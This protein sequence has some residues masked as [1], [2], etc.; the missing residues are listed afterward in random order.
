MSDLVLLQYRSGGADSKLLTVSLCSGRDAPDP[1]WLPA[2]V[3]PSTP[4]DE[5][6][7]ESYQPLSGCLLRSLSISSS[8]P[9][10]KWR[11]VHLHLRFCP[12]LR[13]SEANGALQTQE[14]ERD[15]TVNILR[16]TEKCVII[17]V[18][19]VILGVSVIRELATRN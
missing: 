5:G 6:L 8:S 7:G 12:E 2:T 17:T 15:Q 13:T 9:D 10:D 14:S 11:G 19:P 16:R 1:T 18:T 4:T 3:R